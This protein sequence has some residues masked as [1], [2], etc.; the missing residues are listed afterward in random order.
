MDLSKLIIEGFQV[1]AI[2]TRLKEMDIAFDEKIKSIALIEKFL[3]GHNKIDD[4]QR[5]DGL[6]TVQRI[7][8]KVSAHFGGSEAVDLANNALKKHATYSAHFESVCKTVTNELKLIEQ[9]FS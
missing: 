5:L 4:G 8:S 3:I 6:R 9:A 7:R 1:K 2:R